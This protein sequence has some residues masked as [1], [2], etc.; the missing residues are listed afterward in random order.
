MNGELPLKFGTLEVAVADVVEDSRL[1][2]LKV[3]D[4]V[5]NKHELG[6][7]IQ[8]LQAKRDALDPP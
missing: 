2:Q 4:G 7:L 6:M 5:L 1:L 8:F 3:G